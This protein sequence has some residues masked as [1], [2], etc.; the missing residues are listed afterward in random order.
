MG[1]IPVEACTILTISLHTILIIFIYSTYVPYSFSH[2]LGTVHRGELWSL[3]CPIQWL[4]KE[5]GR[6]WPLFCLFYYPS[7]QFS[8]SLA[9]EGSAQ[10]DERWLRNNFTLPLNVNTKLDAKTRPCAANLVPEIKSTAANVPRVYEALF[11][12]TP[13]RGWSVEVKSTSF[14]TGIDVASNEIARS[15]MATQKERN[16]PAINRLI[17]AA[18]FIQCHCRLVNNPSRKGTVS[19][20]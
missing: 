13:A 3:V 9:R 8:F 17:D 19:A 11:A 14:V 2:A 5:I 16:A 20:L 18:V 10:P 1:I 6:T 7:F 4:Q 15:E 12:A